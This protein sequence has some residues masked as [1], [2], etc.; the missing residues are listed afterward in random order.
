MRQAAFSSSLGTALPMALNLSAITQAAAQSTGSGGYRALVCVFL[1]GGNDAFNTVL[2]TDTTSWNHYQ[3]TR[4]PA[5]GSVPIALPQAG[6]APNSSATSTSPDRLGGVLPIAHAGRAVHTGRQ[7]AMHPALTQARSL[8]Q[9]GRM[10]VLAN[11][12]TLTRPT[13]KT[14]WSDARASKPTKLFSH[15]DQQSTWQSFRPEGAS[16]GWGGLMGDLL[17][18]GNATGRTG[19]EAALIKKSFTCMTPAGQSVWLSGRNVIPYQSHPT[20]VMQLGYEKGIYSNSRLYQGVANIMGQLSQSGTP[21]VA[22]R[23]LFAAD[24][25]NITQR[26]LQAAELLGSS[27]SALGSAP[28]STSGV[29]DAYLDPLLKYTS[30]VSGMSKIN[31][32]AVQLQMVARLIDTNR[33]TNLGMNRQFFM[34]NMGG[35]DTHSSQI[36]EHA[37]RM[38]QLDHAL[39][40][41]DR[42]LGGMPAGDMR[43][44]VTTFT[45]SEFGRT[46]TSNGDGTDH[47]WGGHQLIMGGA[48][49]GTEVY[50]T[51]PT[52]STANTS[53]VFSS[54]DQIQNGVLI[55]TTSVDQ[56]AYTL[57][58]WMGVSD[59][60]L[61][62]I[63]PN[64]SQ[65][66]SSSYDLGFMR[67]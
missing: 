64:L 54:P 27:L 45:A 1:T 37:E 58:K 4:K 52:Y 19:A 59:S 60:N 40:Y 44:Q 17:M 33:G 31:P 57:G 34:V 39:A 48:V 66:N 9:A 30:P 24:M 38:A 26:G 46:F 43:S 62:A 11:V 3:N 23:N 7:F 53:G 36:S 6:V 61:Q 8:Y 21:V 25:Q 18:S 56:Y 22:P 41:F 49:I 12:G 15:N 42:V 20:N 13:T 65:F 29:G 55:P 14:D 47:G 32:L 28:W 16:A 50:G 63:L 67:A 10:A 51:F 35:F 2:A 5:D